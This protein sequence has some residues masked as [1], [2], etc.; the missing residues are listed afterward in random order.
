MSAEQRVVGT[1]A[2]SAQIGSGSFAVVWRA[3]HVES[4]QEAAVKEIN[5]SKLNAKLRQSLESEVS[6]LKRINHDNIVK[7]HEVLE[8]ANRLYLVM[9][10]CAGGDLAHFLRHVKRVPELTAQHLMRQLAAGLRQMWA[11]HLVHRDLKPQNLLLSAAVPDATLKIADFGFARNLQPQGLA[12]TLC[13]S[14]LYMAPEI[15]HFHKYDA[16]ADLW[17]I[18][19][20][21]YELVVGRPP[22]TGANQFQ[23]LRNIERSDARVPEAIAATLSPACRHLIHCLLRRNP[24]ERL[25]FEEFFRHPFVATAEELATPLPPRAPYSTTGAIASSLAAAST[26]DRALQQQQG[27]HLLQFSTSAPVL[28]AAIAKS[29]SATDIPQQVLGFQQQQPGPGGIVRPAGLAGV[30][31]TPAGGAAVLPGGLSHQ[32][33]PRGAH[34]YDSLGG[35]A[36]RQ[37]LQAQ[38]RRPQ[39]VPGHRLASI[40]RVQGFQPAQLPPPLQQ[41]GQQK[42]QSGAAL[43]LGQ[44][45]R[46]GPLSG[47]QLAGSQYSEDEDYVLVDGTLSAHTA[48]GRSSK[49]E[50]PPPSRVPSAEGSVSGGSGHTSHASTEDDIFA[51]HATEP[52]QAAA[53]TAAGGGP[54]AS[55]LAAGSSR[56]RFLQRVAHIMQSVAATRQ[57]AA[58]P[59]GEG[60]PAAASSTAHPATLSP[61]AHQLLRECL[62]LHLAALQ[63]LEHAIEAHAAAAAAAPAAVGEQLQPQQQQ[64]QQPVGMQAAHG[65]DEQPAGAAASLPRGEEAREEAAADLA[66]AGLQLLQETRAGMA[67]AEAAASLLDKAGQE[68]SPTAVT[69]AAA[70]LAEAEAALP[71]PWELL[72]AAALSWGREA[73]VDELLGNQARSCQLYARSGA[74]LSFLCTEAA[75]LELEPPAELAP[76]DQA[77][78]RKYTAAMAA[79]WAACAAAAEAS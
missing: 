49:H 77:R 47:A 70:A 25:S 54:A 31:G 75:T 15:L 3:R 63:L 60:V 9:E 58:T 41:R 27:Q 18:G 71:D 17:S 78:L 10:F 16:K 19:A 45:G 23:L 20:I 4:G 57:L 69:P 76:A 29:R 14:P 11:H 28:P 66:E 51:V 2:L 21:L 73:A 50:S 12:E 56:W 33:K 13:G 38:Q 7:L 72:F 46:Q 35:G 30:G 62:S 55:W 64:Q 37:H 26:L 32:L 5:L 42:A 48:V 79:R 8:E 43:G 40:Q 52:G 59:L 1:W 74:V 61:Q 39:P 53:L 67:A 24:V 34:D 36:Q 22:F 68:P 44:Q 65:G 6:I